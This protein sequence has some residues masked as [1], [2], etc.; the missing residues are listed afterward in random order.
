VTLPADP[1]QRTPCSEAFP[2]GEPQHRPRAPAAAI[3][4]NRV[5]REFAFRPRAS[6]QDVE[7]REVNVHARRMSCPVPVRYVP[8]RG[9]HA[10]LNTGWRSR[11]M[12][13]DAEDTFTPV[14]IPDAKNRIA[15]RPLVAGVNQVDYRTRGL[16]ACELPTNQSDDFIRAALGVR[17]VKYFTFSTSCDSAG[18]PPL[19]GTTNVPEESVNVIR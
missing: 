15:V 3:H 13:P 7:I 2:V 14:I 5:A 16:K 11:A 18:W 10:F 17:A 4:A 12:T 6:S 9:D 1:R 8:L 19:A